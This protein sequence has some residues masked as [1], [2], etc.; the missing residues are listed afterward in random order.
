MG[1]EMAFDIEKIAAELVK[2]KGVLLAKLDAAER[3][4]QYLKAG[5][6][7]RRRDW[8][9]LLAAIEKLVQ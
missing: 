9:D 2:Q 8:L 5:D 4:D 7:K 3:A 1:L 6:M